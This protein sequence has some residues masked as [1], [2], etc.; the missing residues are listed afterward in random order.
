MINSV[1]LARVEQSDKRHG[2]ASQGGNF[3][4]L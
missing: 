4:L 1:S 2:A 3:F